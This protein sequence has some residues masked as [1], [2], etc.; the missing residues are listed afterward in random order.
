MG[1]RGS[2]IAERGR[3][4]STTNADAR[5][6]CVSRNGL[7]TLCKDEA[8]AREIAMQC[9]R[10]WPLGRPHR[11][12]LLGDVAAEREQCAAIVRARADRIAAEAERAAISDPDEVSALRAMAWQ[13]TVAE[14][15]ILGPNV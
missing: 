7:A 13:L 5:W 12:A 4:V 6:Y 14:R 10:S 3:I 2:S 8:D 11:A 1:R 15:E 9:D